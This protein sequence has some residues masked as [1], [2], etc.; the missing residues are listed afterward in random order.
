MEYLRID[1]IKLGTIRVIK[2][3]YFVQHKLYNIIY[4]YYC[5]Q[6]KFLYFTEI[7]NY[8]C[9][10]RRKNQFLKI[11]EGKQKEEIKQRKQIQI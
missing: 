11:Y 4:K 3:E 5:F 2:C 7:F 1:T 8:A 9:E 6:F 10:A